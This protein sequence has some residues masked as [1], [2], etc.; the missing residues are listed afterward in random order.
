MKPYFITMF[1]VMAAISAG[2]AQQGNYNFNNFGNRSI[3]LSGNVTGSV[4]DIA[5]A[6]YNPARLTEVGDTR[7]EFNAKAY[8]L[9]T[10]KVSNVLGEDATPSNTN[11][12]GV[13]SMAGGTFKLFGTRFAFSFL[14]RTRTNTSINYFS[15]PLTRDI[16]E[17]FPGEEEYKIGLDFNSFIRD[18]WFGLT[19]AHKLNDRLSLGISGFGSSY[20]SEGRNTLEY[21]VIT[22]EGGVAFLQTANSYRQRSYGLVLKVGAN[23]NL[24]FMDVGLNVNLPY[25]E[26]FQEGRFNFRNTIAGIGSSEDQVIDNDYR[27]LDSERREP[28]G[29][30]LGAGIPIGKS[31]LHINTDYVA[32]QGGYQR[33]KVPAIDIGDGELTEISFR[34]ERRAVVNFG[35]GAEVYV[36]DKLK[37]YGGFSTDFNSLES[38]SSIFDFSGESDNGINI[39]ANFIHGSAG[40][41]YRA[42]WATIILG[43]TFTAGSSSFIS[44]LRPGDEG[45][46]S[47]DPAP[48]KVNYSRWQ[49]IVGLEFP[50][51]EEKVKGLIQTDE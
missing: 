9:S 22:N 1:W 8:Q 26:V 44:P 16:L 21:T 37:T 35:I 7:F 33:I 5:L 48:T 15:E 24:P 43:A 31:K 36:H 17:A 32:A 3:L 50:F 23:Y 25:I 49:F 13:P 45:L 20:K 18:E 27:E 6:F 41:D 4:E 39:G 11:F 38:D 29:V 19:W 2:W 28:F 10:L 47:L 30:S 14:S 51:I 42:S 34:D 46:E 12:N 40:I